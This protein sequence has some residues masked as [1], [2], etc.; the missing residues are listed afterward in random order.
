MKQCF[1]CQEIKDISEFYRHKAMAD[2]HLNKCIIC[3]KKD[4]QNERIR[5]LNN[6]A[7][8]EWELDRCRIKARKYREDGR[9]IKTMESIESKA[10]WAIKNAHKIKAQRMVMRAIRSG[11][12][13]KQS[14]EICQD[15]NTQAHHDDYTKPLAVRWLC[16]RH[17]NDHHIEMRRIERLI[18][19]LTKTT[20]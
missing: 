17:H 8:V 13:T 2:G 16:V 7:W 9:V 5:N 14:C 15:P 20:T 6:P 3:T 1:K 4:S 10:R 11:K 12:I 19:S 18:N